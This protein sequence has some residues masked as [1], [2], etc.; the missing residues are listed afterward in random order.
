MNQH[1][2]KSRKPR[3]GRTPFEQTK[4]KRN[5]TKQRKI[6]LIYSGRSTTVMQMLMYMRFFIGH[7]TR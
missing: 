2:H 1:C 7:G 3:R 5:L 6:S 4:R